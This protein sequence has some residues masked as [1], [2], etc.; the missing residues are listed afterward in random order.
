MDLT[1]ERTRPARA[2]LHGLALC[3]TGVETLA[4]DLLLKADLAERPRRG[5]S[6]AGR[7][8]G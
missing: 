1:R 3:Q 6:P 7:G 5:E 2:N 8:P 4:G